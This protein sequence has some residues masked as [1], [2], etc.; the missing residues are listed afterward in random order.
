MAARITLLCHGRTTAR[1]SAFPADELLAAGETERAAARAP[2][3]AE[4][5]QVLMSPARAARQT[6]EAFTWTAT[7]DIHLADIDLGR[8]RG[9]RLAEIEASEPGALAA[10]MEDADWAAHGGESRTALARRV[11]D[12]LAERHLSTGHLLAVTHP[13]VIQSAMLG[14]LDAPASAFRHIDVPPLHMLDIR[15]DGRRWTIRSLGRL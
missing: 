10:W 12:W 7:I 9:R 14:I 11:A 15:S 3:L 13:A 4:I 5:D 8:W 2:A 1:A 6:A